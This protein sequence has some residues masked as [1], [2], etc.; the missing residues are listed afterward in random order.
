MNTTPTPL[1]DS[2]EL[3]KQARGRWVLVILFA[4]FFAPILAALFLNSRLSDWQPTATK[5]YGELIVP[6]VPMATEMPPVTGGLVAPWRLIWRVKGACDVICMERVETLARIHQTLGRHR[7]KLEILVLGADSGAA[8]QDVAVAEK[9]SAGLKAR[10]L[11]ADGLYL[12]DPLGNAMMYYPVDADTTGLRKDLDRL[13]RH[14]KF[15]S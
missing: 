14:S 4:L 10:G 12:I 3:P 5:N 13:I 9:V 8:A 7:D 6:V 11:T 1:P 2:A 15:R